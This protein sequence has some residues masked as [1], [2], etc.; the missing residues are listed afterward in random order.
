MLLTALIMR[1][2]TSTVFLSLALGLGGL[3]WAGFG[4]NKLSL[5]T[6]KIQTN[7]NVKRNIHTFHL[8]WSW[9]SPSWLKSIWTQQTEI[10]QKVKICRKIP[11]NNEIRH[12]LGESLGY[13]ATV[14]SNSDGNKQHGEHLSVLT[15]E[16]IC[17]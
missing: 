11:D 10:M 6:K 16:L 2:G 15:K 14:C 7:K 8:S 13:S 5:S 17:L 12:I 4:V 1:R 3:S 9:K